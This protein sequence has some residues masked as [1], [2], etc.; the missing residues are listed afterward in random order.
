MSQ[1][2]AKRKWQESLSDY[3]HMKTK[4]RIDNNG[5]FTNFVHHA[6]CLRL[7]SVLSKVLSISM[8][9]FVILTTDEIFVD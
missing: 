8:A 9:Y 1:I 2:V 3:Q 5:K 6:T 4:V 7:E